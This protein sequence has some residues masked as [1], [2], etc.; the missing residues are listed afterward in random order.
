[1]YT[2]VPPISAGHPRVACLKWL[3]EDDQG[4]TA[5]VLRRTDPFKLRRW[6][7]MIQDPWRDNRH[8]GAL[9][10]LGHFQAR[11]Y[12]QPR[13]TG[14]FIHAPDGP[15][16]YLVTTRHQRMDACTV[17]VA[18]RT[19]PRTWSLTELPWP[20]FLALYMKEHGPLAWHRLR[21]L[22]MKL[23]GLVDGTDLNFFLG[24]NL[25]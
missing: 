20:L 4:D 22:A 8:V 10:L 23:G 12:A 1:M 7:G 2:R 21:T 17:R 5:L 3:A 11:R 25:G 6:A 9:V 24:P 18:C 15:E 16:V 13:S 19:N 14:I